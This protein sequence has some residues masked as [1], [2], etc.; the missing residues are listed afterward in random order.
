MFNAQQKDK[1]IVITKSKYFFKKKKSLYLQCGTVG[2]EPCCGNVLLENLA[3][4][5]LRINNTKFS[6]V[7]LLYCC[8]NIHC[9][10][11]LC[12]FI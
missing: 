5:L 6:A 10:K 9:S 1:R 7:S 4:R 11:A 2:N 3:E 12:L 8:V